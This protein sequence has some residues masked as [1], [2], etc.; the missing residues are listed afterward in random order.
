MERVCAASVERV[1]LHPSSD[2]LIFSNIRV[3]SVDHL[4]IFSLPFKAKMKYL[5]VATCM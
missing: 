3:G 4:L 1:V 2:I 5:A